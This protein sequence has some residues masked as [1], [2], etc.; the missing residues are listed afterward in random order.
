MSARRRAA[1]ALIAAYLPATWLTAKFVEIIKGF[2]GAGT[3]C[4]YLIAWL[5]WRLGC[6]DARMVNRDE[7]DRGLRYLT[8]GNMA[9]PVAGAKA[10]GSWRTTG[11]PRPGDPMYWALDVPILRADGTKD[12]REHFNIF[13]EA[14]GDQWRTADAGRSDAQGRQMAEYVT[15]TWHESSRKA[16]FYGGQRTLHGYIDLD[17]VPITAEPPIPL[18]DG[19]SA[20]GISALVIMA[21]VGTWLLW[22]S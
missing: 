1:L 9:V 11:Q 14:N 3:T 4:G 18:P 8:G 19:A 22:R 16:E 12:W 21:F 6:V 2:G 17:A 10:N 7:P 20:L 5:L 13:I 15:R